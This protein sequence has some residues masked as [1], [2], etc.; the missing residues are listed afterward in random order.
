MNIAI[1]GTRTPTKHQTFKLIDFIAKIP[2]SMI[3]TGCA[4]GIDEG[5]VREG[6]KRGHSV[7]GI[8]P[9]D[10]YN[11][12]V[13]ELCSEIVSLDHL[14]REERREARESVIKYHPSFKELPNSNYHR[15]VF[16]LHARNFIIIRDAD[17]L[18][19]FPKDMSGGTM[20]SVRIAAA[21][22]IPFEII[23]N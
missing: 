11:R 6:R 22:Q 4:R 19:A 14:S 9:W 1:T 15:A 2:Q 7:R 13:Q 21:L 5:A 10:N 16:L 3:I 23:D 17:L 20:Q 8:I 18:A 12:D